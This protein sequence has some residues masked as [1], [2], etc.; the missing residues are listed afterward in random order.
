MGGGWREKYELYRGYNEAT[1]TMILIKTVTTK[2]RE[3]EKRESLRE[4]LLLDRNSS[5]SRFQR[6]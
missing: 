2:Q 5:S 6:K 3:K 1:T 4:R